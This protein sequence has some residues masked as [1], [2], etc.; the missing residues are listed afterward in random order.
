MSSGTRKISAF[1]FLAIEIANLAI[2]RISI[3]ILYLYRGL[4][5]TVLPAIVVW[6][7]LGNIDDKIRV[8][9]ARSDGVEE[10][11]EEQTRRD[12]GILE[13]ANRA[14]VGLGASCG[15]VCP[16]EHLGIGDWPSAA[17]QVRE[18]LRDAHSTIAD[19]HCSV[20]RR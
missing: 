6:S 18:S 13:R 16:L 14:H 20:S 12:R 2:T 5:L 8:N 3:P 11:E 4:D 19:R 15:R 9:D 1:I 7:R 10:V 17:G